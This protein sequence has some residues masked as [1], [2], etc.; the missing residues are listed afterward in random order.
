MGYAAVMGVGMIVT[1][2]GLATLMVARIELRGTE[3]QSETAQADT[4]ARTSLEMVALRLSRNPTWRSYYS[5][6]TWTQNETCAG[7]PVAFKLVDSDGSLTDDAYDPVRVHTR[8]VVGSATRMYSTLLTPD[9]DQNMNLL[10]N[11]DMESGVTGWALTGGGTLSS[12]G[13]S[14][15]GGASSTRVAAGLLFASGMAQD[16]TAR[17]QNNTTYYAEVWVRGVSLS[18]TKKVFLNVTTSTGTYNYQFTASWTDSNW[19]LMSGT[20]QTA[21]AGNLVSAWWG[22]EG[23]LLA[24]LSGD[25]YVDDARLVVGNIP[26]G[27]P[28]LYVARG[29]VRREITP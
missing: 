1:V 11:G 21:W 15:H 7:Y 13:T 17:V 14:P 2:I 20:F 27:S 8:C 5:H 19:T 22:V 10:T 6:D 23:S 18:A 26:A 4:I 3:L 9:A 29:S 16:V 25:I 28:T 24:L 12:S